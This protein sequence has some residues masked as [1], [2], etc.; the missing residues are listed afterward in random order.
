MSD[1]SDAGCA[2]EDEA[3]DPR[4]EQYVRRHSTG[5]GRGDVLLIGVAHDHPASVARVAHIL[6]AVDPDVLALELPS[7][8][9]PLFRLYAVDE[10]VPP[11]LGGEMSTA[12][13]TAGDVRIAG[14]DGPNAAYFRRLVQR[15]V[16]E[17]VSTEDV[18]EVASDVVK[19][20]GQALACRFGAVIGRLTPVTPKVYTHIAYDCASF[21][22]PSTQARHERNHVAQR[23]AFLRVVDLPRSTALIDAAREETMATRLTD[24]RSTGDVVAVIGIEH[25]DELSTRLA[26]E[27]GPTRW[28]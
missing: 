24:L 23:R 20:V 6:D 16:T 27:A 18:R 7:L 19:G 1:C 11:R 17:R 8:A 3:E 28:R 4:L 9:I 5:D 22:S 10:Y 25:L 15:V 21:D 2:D 14:I 13:Q 26:D 12:I